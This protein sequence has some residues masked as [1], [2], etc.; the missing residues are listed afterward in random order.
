MTTTLTPA[1][2]QTILRRLKHGPQMD[3]AALAE[4]AKKIRLQVLA[5]REKAA[6]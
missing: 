3:R 2:R 6:K 1:E 5:K 4:Y